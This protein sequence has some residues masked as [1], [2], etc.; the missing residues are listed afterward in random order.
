MRTNGTAIRR[1]CEKMAYDGFC[2]STVGVVNMKTD[3]SYDWLKGMEIVDKRDIDYW[4]IY[5]LS[6][7]GV[8]YTNLIRTRISI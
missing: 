6:C 7:V 3:I 1:Q 5:I 4:K 2:T 8:F